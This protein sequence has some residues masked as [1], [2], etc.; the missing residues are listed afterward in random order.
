MNAH[1]VPSADLGGGAA[2]ASSI[3]TAGDIVRRL[4]QCDQLS[5]RTFDFL[6][7]AGVS[8]EAMVLPDPVM[9][10]RVQVEA[11]GTFEFSPGGGKALIFLQTDPDGYPIDLIALR[12]R[13]GR[14]ASWLGAA[15]VLGDA[16]PLLGLPTMVHATPL[17]WLRA[18]RSGI[19]II[20]DRKAASLL[21]DYGGRLMVEDD[22]Q[23]REL[24]LRLTRKP[25][26]IVVR[27]P[28]AENWFPPTR[29]KP[30]TSAEVP[31]A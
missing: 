26:Q 7:E 21:S 24:E 9:C 31:Y 3:M 18:G 2:S 6:R 8:V 30:K 11:D 27:S 10:A 28:K 4:Y 13:G 15:A 1:V 29:A 23:R 16:L 19:V 17:E 14:L 5:R 25:P 12:E 22:R 20:D